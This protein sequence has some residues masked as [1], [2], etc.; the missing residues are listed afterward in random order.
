MP[1]AGKTWAKHHVAKKSFF[2]AFRYDAQG[3]AGAPKLTSETVRIRFHTPAAY[4]PY[5]EPVHAASEE[6]KPRRLE[7]WIV[8][9]DPMTPVAARAHLTNLDVD[10]HAVVVEPYLRCLLDDDL[11]LPARS[12]EECDSG[13]DELAL[14]GLSSTHSPSSASWKHSLQCSSFIET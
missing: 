14:H 11:R 13:E 4:Y 7:G 8:T 10:T 5:M 3:D 1:P 9:R 12:D 6:G 2:V